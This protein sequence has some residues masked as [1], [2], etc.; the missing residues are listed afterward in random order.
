VTSELS[1]THLSALAQARLPLVLIDPLNS[2]RSHVVSVG[3]TNF[4]GGL[5]ATQ[6]LISLGH[7]RIAYVG[8]TA[9]PFNANAEYYDRYIASSRKMAKA[10]NV[11]TTSTPMYASANDSRLAGFVHAC[12][13]CARSELSH[14]P[15][16]LDHQNND[17]G[18]QYRSEIFTT[19]KAQADEAAKVIA[20]VDEEGK[21]GKKVVTKVEMATTFVRAEDYH[22]DYLIKHPNGY[23]DHFIRDFDF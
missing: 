21:W 15:T 5:T 16:M 20:K 14:D 12:E 13:M 3:S 22:Q 10:V 17:W 11:V 7:T 19:T 6:H 2:P 4:T 23:N 8:G 9:I 1:P 18:P